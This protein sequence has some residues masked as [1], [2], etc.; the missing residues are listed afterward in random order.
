MGLIN[1]AYPLEQLSEK[2]QYWAERLA[3]IPV[4][5]LAAMKLIVNQAY[6]NMGLASTQYLGTILD[7]IMRNTPEGREF[8]RTAQQQGV[9]ARRSNSAM[10]PSATTVN[11]RPRTSLRREEP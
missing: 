4:T 11:R 2:T 5:Q 1:F 9:A 10:R 7:G 3:Q 6:E 8:V